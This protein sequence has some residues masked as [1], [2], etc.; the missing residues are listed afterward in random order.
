MLTY[1]RKGP[2]KIYRSHDNR[3]SFKTTLLVIG[4]L[5]V[6]GG[7]AVTFA[8]VTKLRTE[9]QYAKRYSEKNRRWNM[10]KCT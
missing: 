6:L 3:E 2:T 9:I 1:P 8:R 10:G 7:G 5:F 4:S